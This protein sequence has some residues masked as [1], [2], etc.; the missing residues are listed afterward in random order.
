MENEFRKYW[1]RCQ[2]YGLIPM[3][4][5]EWKAVFHSESEHRA[6]APKGGP[7]QAGCSRGAERNGATGAGLK[8]KTAHSRSAQRNGNGALH[9]Q[10]EGGI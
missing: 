6:D 9:R 10:P 2:Y 8:G 5:T 3:T 4:F 1:K 7:V